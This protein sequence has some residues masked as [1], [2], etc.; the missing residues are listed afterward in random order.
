MQDGLAIARYAVSQSDRV[1][2]TAMS[3]RDGAPVGP[4]IHIRIDI[5]SLK[6]HSRNVPV[7]RWDPIRRAFIKTTVVGPGTMTIGQATPLTNT[8]TD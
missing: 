4:E 5:A 7:V 1:R 2:S 3:D 8:L 6:L